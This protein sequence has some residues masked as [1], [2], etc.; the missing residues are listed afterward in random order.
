MSIG[1]TERLINL[2]MALLAAQRFIK[3]SEIFRVVAG[4]SGSA[5][6]M[7]RMFERDK[8]DLR[9]LGIN[10]EVGGLDPLFEDEPGYRIKSTDYSLSLNNLNAQQLSLLAL[11]AKTWQ[12]AIFS[13]SAQSALR[14]LRSLGIENDVT[15]YIDAPIHIATDNL[16]FPEIWRTTI[17]FQNISF[18]YPNSENILEPR[19]IQPYG[20]AAWRGQWYLVGRDINKEAIRVFKIARI[21]NECKAIGQI[22]AFKPPENF[23]ISEHLVMLQESPEIPIVVLVRKARCLALRLKSEIIRNDAEWDTI[24]F[25]EI[26]RSQTL[27]EILWH[28][29][30]VIVVSPAD[31]KSSVVES[32]Q[33]LVQIG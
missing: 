10:I 20:V 33:K 3:K 29:A 25:S 26:N 28:G 16:N 24:Q 7:E 19:E 2:T 15:T 1:K 22:K 11:A 30:D 6:A 12:E 13:D 9:N 27:Q 17:N 8:D 4:Y 5:E 14:K 21:A 32:L 31:L 23:N 18:D